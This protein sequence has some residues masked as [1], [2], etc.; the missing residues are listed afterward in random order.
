MR[1]RI[2]PTYVAV[3]NGLWRGETVGPQPVGHIKRMQQAAVDA[4]TGL[5][6]K[7]QALNAQARHAARNGDAGKLRELLDKGADPNAPSKGKGYTLAHEAARSSNPAVMAVLIDRGG[8]DLDRRA[9]IAPQPTPLH[10]AALL[11]NRPV[12]EMLIVN[13]ASQHL[14]A[15]PLRE[16][17]NQVLN[18]IAGC[19][20]AITAER[21]THLR[22]VRATALGRRANMPTV[23]DLDANPLINALA[24]PPTFQEVGNQLP[25]YAEALLAP[26]PQAR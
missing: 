8:L 19:T 7:P 18:D 5:A 6:S 20:P 25:S 23:D 16:A 3:A 13:G 9:T 14:E 21:V 24:A 10:I 26:D 2:D 17:D 22:D 1:Q 11:G 4:L 12:A 15:T